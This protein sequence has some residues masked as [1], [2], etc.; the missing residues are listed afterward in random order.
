MIRESSG[1]SGVITAVNNYSY[2]GDLEM[3]PNINILSNM[4]DYKCI[5]FL[6]DLFKMY[7]CSRNKFR[8][9]DDYLFQIIN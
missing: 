8:L 4:P 9:T 5:D 7:I 6:S 3:F 2:N 1:G